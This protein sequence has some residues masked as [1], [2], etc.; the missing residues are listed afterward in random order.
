MADASALPGGSIPALP[1]GFNPAAPLGDLEIGVLAAYGLFGVTCCQTWSYYTRF[2]N[3]PLTLKLWVAFIWLCEAAHIAA[4]A[5]TLFDATITNYMHPE[6]LG[7]VSLSMLVSILLTGVIA[8]CVQCFFGLRILKLSHSPI[9]PML[10]FLLAAAQVAFSIVPFVGFGSKNITAIA[11]EQAWVIYT[12]LGASAA[13]DLLI[14]AAIVA[15]L[16]NEKYHAEEGTV[17]VLEKIIMWAIET[18]LI[19]SAAALLALVLFATMPDSFAWLAVEVVVAKLYSN[20]LLASLNSRT[21]LRSLR[22]GQ[23]TMRSQTG[24]N[25]FAMQVNMSTHVEVSKST[26]PM[27]VHQSSYESSEKSLP[28]RRFI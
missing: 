20:S 9:I 2:P 21:T 3:D 12:E 13:N 26:L 8:A 4:I 5:Q 27:H 17:V 18:G 24:V 25:S 14:A 22:T 1:P 19:T 23:T 15:H 28:Q 16:W 11:Q 10:V 6:N 7:D